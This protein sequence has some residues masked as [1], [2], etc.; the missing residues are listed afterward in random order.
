MTTWGEVTTRT[1]VGGVGSVTRRSGMVQAATMATA[2]SGAFM[3]A[4]RTE[5]LNVNVIVLP[6]TAC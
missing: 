3:S 1:T 4:N 2:T 6:P 5:I